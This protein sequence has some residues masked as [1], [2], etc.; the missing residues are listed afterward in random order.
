LYIGRL[1][2]GIIAILGYIGAILT[3]L[4]LGL[5]GGGGAAVSIP[6]LVY[7]FHVPSPVATGYGPGEI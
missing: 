6:I 5:L 2:M 4:V 3:G 7:A 1:Y